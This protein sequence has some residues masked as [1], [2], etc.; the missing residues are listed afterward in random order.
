MSRDLTNAIRV[1]GGGL[2]AAGVLAAGAAAGAAVERIVLARSSRP[3]GDLAM[4][5]FNSD[6]LEV[7][8]GDGTV[9]HVEI[10]EVD[11]PLTIIFCHG[12]ALSLDSW[13]F[14]RK[15]LQGQARMVFYDQRSHG[16]SGRADFDS[17]HVDQLGE[18]LGDVIAAVAPTGP[19][20]LVGH[21]MGGM[22]VM[23]Y[24]E[25][26]PEVIRERV[27][28][29][30]F[31][32]SSAGGLTEVT[33]GLPAPFGHIF[34]RIA[35]PAAAALA[36]RRNL[37][38]RG[39]RTSND[40]SLLLTRLYSFGSVASDQAGQLVSNMITATPIDVLAEFLPALQDHD[41]LAALPILQ[42][43]EVLVIV[44]DSDRLTPRSH[45]E[46]IVSRIP[47]AEFVVI[48]DGGHM[49]NIEHHEQVDELLQ[50]LLIRVK[51]D[52]G[53]VSGNGVA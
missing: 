11:S 2:L 15:D 26:Q 13:Y 38:E 53:D 39:R 33:L 23:A 12:Y 3:D 49:V 1:V 5:E 8:A 25:Q 30:A 35:S 19:L 10:D 29:V 21:S 28:G 51:R 48:K 41:K 16:R 6:N 14:Q 4:D 44:G 34:H 45:S 18:D 32:S 47:G 42:H 46:E 9:L 52:I 22:S 20:M 24:A 50:Q 17:H 37:V 31:I 36:R 43:A 40:L 27:Y 7:I